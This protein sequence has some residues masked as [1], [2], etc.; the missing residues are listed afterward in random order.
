MNIN[1]LASGNKQQQQLQVTQLSGKLRQQ[2][3]SGNMSLQVVKQQLKRLNSNISMGQAY[4]NFTGQENKTISAN[5]QIHIPSLALL[6]PFGSGL[7]NTQ[8]QII[9][10]KQRPII[11][12]TF[13]THNFAYMQYQVSKFISRFNLNI[14]SPAKSIF[15]IQA[16]NFRNNK[17]YLPKIVINASGN[18]NK[19]RVKL[20]FVYHNE[21]FNALLKGEHNKA[22]WLINMP[23][24]TMTSVDLGDWYLERPTSI[25]LKKNAFILKDFS[26]KSYQQ[27]IIANIDLLKNNQ[28]QYI[29]Q[30][31]NINIY[32]LSLKI[33]SL[34]L[35]K[36]LIIKGHMN[37]NA[38]I[39]QESNK[40]QGKVELSIPHVVINY[41]NNLSTKKW[42]LKKVSYLGTL[43][44]QGLKSQF[45]IAVDKSDHLD[46]NVDIAQAHN[47]AAI[48]TS[49]N[50][51][52]KLTASF[53][54]IDFLNLFL[55]Q[56]R[57]IKG[58]LTANLTG[59]GI[60]HSP[61]LKGTAAIHNASASIPAN[62][63]HLKN[64]NLQVTGGKQ[65]L[66]W[67]ISAGSGSGNL[68]A[69]GMTNY[70]HPKQS[71]INI[72]GNDFTVANTSEYNIVVTPT[73]TIKT[74]QNHIN[75]TGNL[76]IPKANITITPTPDVNR[77][78]SDVK[79]I[80]AEKSNKVSKS[81]FDNIRSNIKLSLGNNVEINAF[82]LKSQ[83]QGNLIINDK[84][85]SSSQATGEI[86]LTQG[87]YNVFG[88]ALTIKNGKLLFAGGPVNNP[89]LDIRAS[90]QIKTFVN[91]TQN[92]LTNTGLSS[93]SSSSSASG[94]N[95]PL[96]AKTITVGASVT[97][98][99]LDPSI[100]LYSDQPDLT[101]ADILSY[102]I[103]GFPISQASNQQGEALWQAASALSANSNDVSGVMQQLKSRFALN[104]IGFESSSYLNTTNN[105]VQQNTS[106]VL[107]KMLSP[108]LYIKYSIGLIEPINTLSAAYT[109]DKHWTAQ[110][111]TNSLGNGVDLIYSWESG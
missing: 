1:L 108:D 85:N 30:S 93:S 71:I 24:L 44:K 95:I 73:I 27:S 43:N 110:T 46:F 19:Q 26:W 35:P 15:S 37:F 92:S 84:S 103:F 87:S 65:Q 42:L 107:G 78:F 60:W 9:G 54:N 106:L 2:A 47:P 25:T 17:L 86:T 55:P 8:G 109:I 22:T 111:E 67:Q 80:T 52:S 34:F 72:T 16:S 28:G 3:L 56:I 90:K 105:S 40:Q 94:V 101:K 13:D 89:E 83:L 49:H 97:N 81:M 82:K 99:M 70:V 41:K 5:W 69:T 88:Q 50:V 77:L 31:S 33:L 104:S 7:I 29:P 48:F 63:L 36:D 53:V 58:S 51:S 91:P 57:K 38:T 61:V 39:Q 96:Q 62:G 66:Y 98:T 64:I 10:T 102:L 32:N 79:I 68:N 45:S 14:N 23:L 18:N 4:I 6:T 11:N 100:S 76:T 12:G 59:H 74:D 21:T 20:H 75:V